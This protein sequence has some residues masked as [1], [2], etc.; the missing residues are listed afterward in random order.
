[1][2]A[3]TSI[4]TGNWDDGPTTWGTSAG[5]YPGSTA[6]Q[7]DT[8]VIAAT[9]NVTLNVASSAS[10]ATVTTITVN[11]GSGGGAAGTLT[12]AAVMSSAWIGTVTTTYTAGQERGHL[13]FAANQAATLSLSTGF[14]PNGDISCD[15]TGASAK[16]IVSTPFAWSFGANATITILA[17]RTKTVL[18]QFSGAP[19]GTY[20]YVDDGAAGDVSG[21]EVG[22]YLCGHKTTSTRDYKDITA[23]GGFAASKHTYTCALSSSLQDN[24]TC[25]NVTRSLVIQGP[26]GGSDSTAVT[27]P[28][29]LTVTA[30]GY[31]E[32]SNCHPVIA[33][34]GTPTLAG[35]S[36]H[37]ARPFL[38]L[39]CRI[40]LTDLVVWST[41]YGTLLTCDAV[42]SIAVTDAFLSG[43]SNRAIAGV[44]LS[45]FAGCIM[46][47]G[48]SMCGCVTGL[49]QAAKYARYNYGSVARLVGCRTYDCTT[50]L[51]PLVGVAHVCQCLF[52]SD[53]GGNVN[54]NTTDV[55]VSGSSGRCYLDDC[56]L[57]A[58]TEVSVGTDDTCPVV[59][60]TQHDQTSAARREWQRYGTTTNA[61]DADFVADVCDQI[62]PSSSVFPF[63][64]SVWF[65]VAASKNPTLTFA[66][67]GGGTLGACSVVLGYSRC[68]LTGIATGGT[69][70]PDTDGGVSTHTVTFSGTTDCAGEVEIIVEVLDSSS[71]LLSVGDLAVTDNL[72]TPYDSG[73]LGLALRDRSVWA[74]GAGGAG[75]PAMI[76]SALI[77]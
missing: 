52:G 30:W 16:H 10:G 46:L 11:A 44:H 22:D 5:V 37:G 3:F 65:P 77:R 8:A 67:K 76:G 69:I 43:S 75:S 49:V 56:L 32:F 54:A 59:V 39:S 60:S 73:A 55:S 33:A 36:V 4:A 23:D 12:V 50:G 26:S 38:T 9:H 29:G 62:D 25:A 19:S 45:G 66:Q 34:T 48:V 61:A 2:A 31:I 17:G 74:G 28:A 6:S 72:D 1:V 51:Q 7:A 63:R 70:T 42:G 21:W 27:F 57:G 68:G 14:A 40:T 20:T 71:G 58:A 13:V 41:I 24:G 53:V 18:A 64:Y 47:D 35:L 15:A